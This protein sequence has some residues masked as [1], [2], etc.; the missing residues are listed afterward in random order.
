[1]YIRGFAFCVG[2]R[3]RDNLRRHG[4][5]PAHARAVE[6]RTGLKVHEHLT[7]GGYP[8]LDEIDDAA[9]RR[10]V[11]KTA[12]QRRRAATDNDENGRKIKGSL[13]HR[14]RLYGR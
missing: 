9:G 10:T 1:M 11:V 4:A 14:R 12:A 6:A 5:G 13:S 7:D 3:R 2:N 8:I